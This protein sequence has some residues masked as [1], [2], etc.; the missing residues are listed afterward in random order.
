MLNDYLF[1]FLPSNHSLIHSFTHSLKMLLESI[2]TGIMG[3]K[4][5]VENIV[6]LIENL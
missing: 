1:K 2:C 5:T 4:N 3:N 6:V